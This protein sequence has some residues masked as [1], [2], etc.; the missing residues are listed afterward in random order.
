MKNKL[1]ILSFLIASY[2][3]TYGE[4]FQTFIDDRIN[5]QEQVKIYEKQ[6]LEAI[7]SQLNSYLKEMQE[8]N[9]SISKLSVQM[10]EENNKSE[11]KITSLKWK[12]SGNINY[13]LFEY[14]TSETNSEFMPKEAYGRLVIG[15][16]LENTALNFGFG[17]KIK[18]NEENLREF[19]TNTIDLAIRQKL[20]N[21]YELG[22]SFDIA[23]TGKDN[24]KNDTSFIRDS[25]DSSIYLKYYTDNF[26]ITFFPYEVKTDIG[27]NLFLTDTENNPGL[28]V[29]YNL[30]D[31]V[32]TKLVLSSGKEENIDKSIN[33]TSEAV[34]GLEYKN[35][36][37]K[38][39]SNIYYNDRSISKDSVSILPKSAFNLASELYI[40]RLTVKTEA[41]F[42]KIDK[43]TLDVK[44]LDK[45]NINNEKGMGF[46]FGLD[47]EVFSA[48]SKK[49]D[50]IRN[51]NLYYNLKFIKNSTAVYNQHTNSSLSL[52]SMTNTLGAMFKFG[53]G[54]YIQPEVQYVKVDDET[55]FK[56]R[57][58]KY[59]TNQMLLFNLK[60]GLSF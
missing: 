31:K 14:N 10:K 41:L 55:Y 35:S 12:F 46:Y 17:S 13:N 5:I 29:N 53:H 7:Q 1:L 57:S 33:R 20:G 9:E 43:D 4:E 26:N 38:L 45:Y 23:F 39:A 42:T 8:L 19:S 52:D 30:T 51:I 11:R 40:N 27:Y 3:L 18:N 59:D 44:I 54:L 56:G 48:Y 47:Y 24:D 25:R 16:Q 34:I 60:A 2:N 15:T 32:K 49:L 21:H 58:N 22:L 36:L 28:S 6:S 37:F 50:M